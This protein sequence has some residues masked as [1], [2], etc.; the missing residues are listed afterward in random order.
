MVS[1]F[2]LA[3]TNT[4]AL[5]VTELIKFYDTGPWCKAA[6]GWIRTLD[7]T[8]IGLVLYHSATSAYHILLL[9]D[10]QRQ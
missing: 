4:L 5:Y 10:V 3:L 2:L 1:H 8:I 6:A 9:K 7:L